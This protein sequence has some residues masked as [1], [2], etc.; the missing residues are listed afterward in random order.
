MAQQQE[1][2]LKILRRKQVEAIVGLSRS[3]IYFLMSQGRFPRQVSLG[4]R[5]AV[6]WTSASIQDWLAEQ[7]SRGLNAA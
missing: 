6:G 4:G 5:R 1:Q 7:V 2:A 3:Q